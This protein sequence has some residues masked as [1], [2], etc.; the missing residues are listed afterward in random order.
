MSNLPLQYQNALEWQTERIIWTERKNTWFAVARTARKENPEALQGFHGDNLM[1]IV[2]EAS[3]VPTEVFE[4]VE[5]ALT[6]ENVII[7]AT[8][9]FHH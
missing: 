5:G 3:G 1:F 9:Q 4:V 7:I 6:K 8:L 2:D